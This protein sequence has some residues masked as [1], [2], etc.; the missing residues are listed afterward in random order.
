MAGVKR[1]IRKTL[2][3]IVVGDKMDKTVMVQ[4]ERMVQD[5]TYKK[6]IRR[7]KKFMAHDEKD[8]CHVG[9]R[10]EIVETRPTSQNKSFKVLK[11]LE[12][13]RILAEEVAG[14]DTK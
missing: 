13:G 4:V 9:D 6:Y 10:V 3:G 11:V 12:R 8:E 2:R 5:P 7:R 1:G 14:N